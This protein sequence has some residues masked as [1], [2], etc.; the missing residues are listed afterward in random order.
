M[1]P[2]SAPLYVV[3]PGAH[4]IDPHDNSEALL[5]RIPVLL[6][7]Q[8]ALPDRVTLRP[9]L[10][11]PGLAV[12]AQPAGSRAGFRTHTATRLFVPRFASVSRLLR[13]HHARWSLSHTMTLPRYETSG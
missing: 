4:A 12:E 9:A 6:D 8:H 2:G 3:E 1:P 11:K 13:S 10:D 5:L 7:L